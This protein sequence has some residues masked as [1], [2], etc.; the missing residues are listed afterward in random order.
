MLII[1]NN[2]NSFQQA[3]IDRCATAAHFPIY[4]ELLLAK[5]N[6]FWITNILQT[7]NLLQAINITLT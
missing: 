5:Y 3:I 6:I 2:I 1:V 7:I 4:F